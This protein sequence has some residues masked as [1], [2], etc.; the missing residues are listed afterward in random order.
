M[1]DI[2]ANKKTIHS[3]IVTKHL[4]KRNNNK[5]LQ[6][7]PPNICSSEETPPPPAHDDTLAQLRTNKS[8]FLKSCFT[9]STHTNTHHHTSPFG[10]QIN[11]QHNT[12]LTANTYKQYYHPRICRRTLWRWPSCRNNGVTAWP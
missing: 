4:N 1:A 8:P 5:I 6:A 12:S 10:K 3:A 7:L 2:S 11:I 9:K